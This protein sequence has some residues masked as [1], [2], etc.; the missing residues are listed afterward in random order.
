MKK[1]QKKAEIRF[2]GASGQ[3][4]PL[5]A[6]ILS[7]AAF[8]G[9]FK[10]IETST[11]E[12][13]VRGGMDLYDVIVSDSEIEYPKPQELDILIALSQEGY[14][15]AAEELKRDSVQILDSLHVGRISKVSKLIIRPL[16]SL[17]YEKTG[18]EEY[19]NFIALGIAA[20]YLKMISERHLFNLIRAKTTG[21][22]RDLAVKAFKEGF[23]L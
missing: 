12:T 15:T 18:S 8:A 20:K 6:Q 1:T 17:S 3:G 2:A 21:K 10:V 9:K 23:K 11:H 16:T 4:I 22:E 14:D 13:D 5:I 19:A 7:E